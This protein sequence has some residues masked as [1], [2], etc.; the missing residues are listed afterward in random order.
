M[1]DRWTLQ[2]LQLLLSKRCDANAHHTVWGSM[3]I[4]DRGE[5]L[6]QRFQE[7]QGTGH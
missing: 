6:L 4:N 1:S 3:N 2:I 5:C 7:D